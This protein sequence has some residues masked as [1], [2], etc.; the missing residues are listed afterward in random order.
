MKPIVLTPQAWRSIRDELHKEHPKSVFALRSKMRKT[1]GFTIREHRAWI[2]TKPSA[3]D[4]T[5]DQGHYEDQVHLDFYSEAKR[6]FFLM[7]YS[8]II[9]SNST[10]KQL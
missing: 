5:I 6:T 9:S 7:K 4:I 1:L 2:M 3:T 8:E 10:G